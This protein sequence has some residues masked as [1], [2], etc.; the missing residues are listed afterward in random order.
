MTQDERAKSGVFARQPL[1]GGQ[2]LPAYRE[3]VNNELRVALRDDAVVTPV[4]SMEV[5]VKR[6]PGP[7]APD[8]VIRDPAPIVG[9]I[10]RT[11]R[12]Y[13]GRYEGQREEELSHQFR[14][15]A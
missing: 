14:H 9:T 10:G 3:S 8:L 6:F 7:D 4:E 15:A 1:K 2:C 13:T 5:V 12:R 11:A